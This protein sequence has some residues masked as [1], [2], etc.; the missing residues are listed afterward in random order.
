MK[1]HDALR[2]ELTNNE[3]HL[4]K[5]K[6]EGKFLGGGV[7]KKKPVAT[8]KLVNWLGFFCPFWL[9]S[10]HAIFSALWS[11]LLWNIFSRPQEERRTDYRYLLISKVLITFLFRSRHK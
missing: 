11:V 5:I 4:E 7:Q 3:P 6:A 10:P 8:P 9:T 1:R 2:S